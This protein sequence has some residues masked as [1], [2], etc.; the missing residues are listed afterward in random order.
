MDE[1]QKPKPWRHIEDDQGYLVP[2]WKR[3]PDERFLFSEDFLTHGSPS[4]MAGISWSDENESLQYLCTY[5]Q[6]LGTSNGV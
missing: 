5:V 3:P 1:S 2:M 4:R 6:Q